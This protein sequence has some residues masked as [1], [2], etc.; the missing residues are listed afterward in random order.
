M[1]ILY[2]AVL[3]VSSLLAFPY[4]LAKMVF[5][6]KYR[7]RLAERLGLKVSPDLASLG[8]HRPVWV[9]AVSVGEVMAATP[10]V[11]R[12]KREWPGLKIVLST[13]TATGRQTA[14]KNLTEVDA[15]LPFP[16]DFP[17]AVKRNLR[18]LNP[19]L[20]ITLET[21]I[22]PNLLMA[23]A[24]KKIP[25]LMVNG[26][27]SESSFRGYRLLGLI[28]RKVI[29]SFS[30]ICMQSEADAARVRALGAPPDRMTVT[31][32]MKYDRAMEGVS[33]DAAEGALALL[34]LGGGSKI[35]VAGSTHRG[36]EEAILTAF[37][38]LRRA[39]PDLI[40][41]VAPRHPERFTEVADLMV[42]R[43]VKM[44]R[45]SQV[46]GMHGAE[47]ILLDSI[48]EL[49]QVYAAATLIFVG[50]SLVPSGGHNPLE[51]AAH[52]KPV[53][54]GPHMDN[55]LDVATRLLEEGGGIRVNSRE[56]LVVRARSL[57]DDGA[58]LISLGERAAATVRRNQGAC[59]A[60]Y[61]VVKKFLIEAG[62]EGD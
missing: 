5:K 49:S 26:R 21:E 31:G 35:F 24:D 45:R 60:T 48:G 11:R 50:G 30:F 22:W 7:Y 33:R 43:G 38:E 32:N 13:V 39:H 55:F 56:E 14:E 29:A 9:H 27:I 47:A 17:W 4:F 54:F 8:R 2:N 25:A 57:L 1:F 36:E 23:L 34:G 44:V 52:G 62:V 19:R 3:L 15:L 51:A 20:F 58:L 6:K 12:I 37:Q 18:V 59:Q 42:A 10:L 41:V 28:F 46:R 53:L 40:L 61:S 16:L